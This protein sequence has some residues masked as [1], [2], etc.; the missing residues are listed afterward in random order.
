MRASASAECLEG[1]AS[2]ECVEG[3]EGAAAGEP[4][5]VSVRRCELEAVSVGQ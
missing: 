3:A 2:A 5:V 4:E 1:A